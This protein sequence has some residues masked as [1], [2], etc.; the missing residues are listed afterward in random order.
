MTDWPQQPHIRRTDEAA[1]E[2][3]TVEDICRGIMLGN[4]GKETG[5]VVEYIRLRRGKLTIQVRILSLVFSF[6]RRCLKN[7]RYEKTLEEVELVF[8]RHDQRNQFATMIRE[9]KKGLVNTTHTPNLRPYMDEGDVIRVELGFHPGTPLS[10]EAKRPILLHGDMP[11][12][13]DLLREVHTKVLNYQN[14]LD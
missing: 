3:R 6:L 12:A 8:I 2:E 9:L 14:G 1:A 7:T 13:K 5:Q 4:L 11:F 10:W